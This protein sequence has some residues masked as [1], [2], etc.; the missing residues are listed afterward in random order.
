MRIFLLGYMGSGKTRLGSRLS[1]KLGLE[2]LDL[3]RLL[4]QKYKISVFNL[5]EKYDEHL[6]RVLEHKLLLEV[7]GKEQIILSLGGGTPCF[8][9][10]MELLNRYGLTIYLKLSVEILADRLTMARKPRPLVQNRDHKS[11]VDQIEYHLKIREAYY[12]KAKIIISGAD[13]D[14]NAL[15]EKIKNYFS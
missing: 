12:Q 7:I 4:E 10:N 5:F 14:V 13:P 3:D 15:E 9:N 2:F 11:L 8:Y 1:E 6:F